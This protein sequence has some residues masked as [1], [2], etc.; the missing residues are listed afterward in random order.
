[1]SDF[2]TRIDELMNQLTLEEKALL[3]VGRD[4]WSTAA[5]ERL[6]IPSVFVTD[7]PTGL[8]KA[9][10]D[11]VALSA[12]IPATCFPTASALA[13]SWNRDLLYRVGAT[14][15]VE[16]Q[17]NNV[18]TLLGPGLNL[19]RSPLGGRNFEYLSEDPVLTG[20]L[21]AAFVNGVQSEGVGACPKH[22]VA[23]ES[24]TERMRSDS[25]VDEQTL[26]EIYLRPFDITIRKSNPWTIMESYNKLNGTYM[27]ENKAMLHD[28]LHEEWGYTGIVMS[29]W[30]AVND[31]VESI[32]AG[33]HLQMPHANTAQLVIDAVNDGS[34]EE[35]RL[36]E[37]VRELLAFIL[38]ADAQR[39]QGIV[40]DP[41]AHH[42][43]ARDVAGECVTLLQNDGS[44]LPLA[45]DANVAVIGHFARQPRIQGGGSSQ[46]NPTRV[47]NLH[48]E[49]S[50]A[51][52][53]EIPYAAGYDG[54]T[55][56]EDLIAEAVSVAR[57][58]DIAIVMIGLPDSWEIEGADREHFDLPEAHTTLVSHVYEAQPNTIVVLV[59]GAA[60]DLTWISYVPTL[61]EGWLTGQAGAGAIAD[62]LSGKV[63]PSGKLSET[64]PFRIEDTPAFTNFWPDAHLRIPYAE[65][66]LT[67]YRWYDTRDIEPAFPFGHGL[68]YTDFE[69]SDLMLS[70]DAVTEGETLRVSFKLT[71]TGQRA[72][73]EVVQLYLQEH[74]PRLPRAVRDLKNFA[75]VELAPGE[76]K[77][78]SIDLTS[79]D[80]A[81]WD[82]ELKRWVVN[83]GDFDV[84]IG[85][86]SRDL[87]L[88]STVHVTSTSLPPK[89]WDRSTTLGE[90]ME[91][92]DLEETVRASLPPFL[93]TEEGAVILGFMKQTPV[94]KFVQMGRMTTE[95]VDDLLM[96]AKMTSG[97]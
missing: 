53:Y 55:T 87:R 69:Y 39:K 8:R 89:V 17:A 80:F 19:K 36:D 65:G 44:L 86:S 15:G 90:L 38:K 11:D 25:I 26:R 35:A 94:H 33:L 67:G 91:I 78:V 72:G 95:Q 57:A 43:I 12:S 84:L 5:I 96:Q 48:A 42:Q 74:H 20:E 3:T 76:S 79:E 6:G 37:I 73:K 92:P 70:A 71:N 27:P 83:T 41:E 68:S 88:Q 4:G 16:A 66:V 10:P 23:N 9:A 14:I 30:T 32:K 45:P 75:K 21:A 58:A 60:V 93:L 46:V 49:L 77:I 40:F 81:Q 82:A 18:Q 7:G 52:G 22:F 47:E 56:N 54:D 51:L 34:L 64:F 24:E 31:R 85:S 1:M 59:N 29:D 97:S 63:N 61:V 13:S 50:A 2:S 28:L 62:V